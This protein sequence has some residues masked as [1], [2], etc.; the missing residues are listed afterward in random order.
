[1]FCR[2]LN[3]N[4]GMR[5]TVF[6]LFVYSCWH[7]LGLKWGILQGWFKQCTDNVKYVASIRDY[8]MSIPTVILGGFSLEVHAK[9]THGDNLVPK[10]QKLTV[11]SLANISLLHTDLL[12]NNDLQDR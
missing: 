10:S 1:M 5:I 12:D 9:H 8:D 2:I 6:Q 11:T 7:A 3:V 4:Y